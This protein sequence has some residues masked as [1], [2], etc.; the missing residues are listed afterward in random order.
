MED[1]VVIVSFLNQVYEVGCGY[2]FV[3]SHL[4]NYVA[5]GSYEENL[6]P[7]ALYSPVGEVSGVTEGIPVDEVAVGEAVGDGEEVVT[8]SLGLALCEIL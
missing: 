3:V 8:A 4:N 7:P 6:V 5:H 1:S 2:G